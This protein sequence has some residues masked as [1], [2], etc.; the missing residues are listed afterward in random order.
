MRKKLAAMADILEFSGTTSAAVATT[1]VP[2]GGKTPKTPDKPGEIT[3]DLTTC[4]ACGKET[5][6]WRSVC[7]HCGKPVT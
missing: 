4:P 2:L 7:R 1:P 3:V 5:E 6:K